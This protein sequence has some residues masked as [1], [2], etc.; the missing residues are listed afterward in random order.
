[1]NGKEQTTKVGDDPGLVVNTMPA[2][3]YGGANP[4][5]RF[6]NVEKEIEL[7]KG[8]AKPSEKAMLDKETAVGGNILTSSKSMALVSVILFV[9]FVFGAG[10]YY[11]WQSRTPQPAPTSAPNIQ[12][13]PQQPQAPTTT[14]TPVVPEEIP[15]TT[16]PPTVIMSKEVSMEFPS[17]LLGDAEDMDN[18][19]IMDIA[20][21]TF[22]T[23][24]GNP[25]TDEDGYNDGHE[26]YNLYNPTGKEPMKLIE[27]GYIDEFS[28]PTFGYKIYFP[29]S[30]AMG[31][32]DKEYRDILFSAM[33]GENIEL[34]VF[35]LGFGQNFADWLGVNAPSENFADLVE[36]TGVFAEKGYR[37]ND[38]LIYYFTDGMR[39]YVL[40]YHGLESTAVGYRSVIKM[41]ARSFRMNGNAVIQPMPII[42]SSGAEI[43]ETIMPETTSTATT[44]M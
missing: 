35:D 40:A 1:M 8:G 16:E 44:T 32:V 7:N 15:T 14:E 38:Y 12:Q 39:V 19:D 18:D 9:F 21:E 22:G 33:N 37:R 23:D 31:N 20:E 30:W 3:F 25:D 29:K 36:F 41:M 27:S 5:I 34:R 17:I 13:T 6:K 43:S 42:E 10:L 11:W 28:N 24:P 26:A 4:V 2:D